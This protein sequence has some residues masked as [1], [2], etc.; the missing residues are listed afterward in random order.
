MTHSG[1]KQT[2]NITLVNDYNKSVALYTD[3]VALIFKRLKTKQKRD[4]NARKIAV[5]C[6][7]EIKPAMSGEN[8]NTAQ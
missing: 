8:M 3:I 5:P 6:E 4:E 2:L 7:T 1:F